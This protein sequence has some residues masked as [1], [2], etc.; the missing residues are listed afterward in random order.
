MLLYHKVKLV[1]N[2]NHEMHYSVACR[3]LQLP[4]V[5][6]NAAGSGS[7]LMCSKLLQ[8]HSPKGSV[9]HISMLASL[10]DSAISML[11]G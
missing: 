7:G 4:V 1:V 6:V 10:S 8:S 2:N 3:T 9:S 11:M 5:T